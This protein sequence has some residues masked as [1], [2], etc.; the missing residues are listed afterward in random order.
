L[1]KKRNQK[2]KKAEEARKAEL[3]RQRETTAGLPRVQSQVRFDT[4]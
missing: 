3:A 1:K 4:I 2:K